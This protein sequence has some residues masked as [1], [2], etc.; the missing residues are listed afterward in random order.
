VGQ[1]TVIPTGWWDT[2]VWCDRWHT[3]VGSP[4]WHST[5]SCA[6][7][8]TPWGRRLDSG[9]DKYNLIPRHPLWWLIL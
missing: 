4:C 7:R 9:F 6:C 1:D 8:S 3:I 2:T 5:K